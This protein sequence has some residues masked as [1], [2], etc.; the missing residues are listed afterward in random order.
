M[1]YIIESGRL[2]LSDV[3]TTSGSILGINRRKISSKGNQPFQT[4]ADRNGDP[5]NDNFINFVCVCLSVD[6][7]SIT[8]EIAAQS[9]W[10]I[11]IGSQVA[12]LL[13]PMTHGIF[14]KTS[15]LFITC[16]KENRP[17]Y[18]YTYNN[19]RCKRAYRVSPSLI[20]FSQSAHFCGGVGHR[21][22]KLFNNVGLN[23]HFLAGNVL[24]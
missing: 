8:F 20:A 15:A 12:L 2:F 22:M 7:I 19:E 17:R 11:T 1:N 18:I 13:S 16:A 6:W 10:F 21:D 5:F 9:Q 14:S 23:A 24:A 3:S 4:M